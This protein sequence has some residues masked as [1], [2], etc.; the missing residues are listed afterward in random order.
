M[1]KNLLV[2]TLV[3]V[4]L[5]L[6]LVSQIQ[7]AEKRIKVFIPAGQFNMEGH[8]Q[9]RSLDWLGKHPKYGHLLR[10]LKKTDGSWAIRDDVTIS[11]QAEHRKK[12]HS[13]LTVGWGCEEHEIG[14]KLKS[15]WKKGQAVLPSPPT[16]GSNARIG[17]TYKHYDPVHTQL[18]GWTVAVDPQLMAAEHEETRREAFKALANHLQRVKY[19]V[20]EDRLTQLQELRFWI[21]LENPKLGNMQYHP[22]RGWLIANGHYP[23]LV[24]HIHI[25]HAKEL[26]DPHMWTKHPY[27]V[28]HELVHSFHDQVLSFD[29]PDILGAFEQAKKDGIYEQVLLYTGQRVRHYGLTDHKEYF[30]EATEAYFGVNDFYLFVRAELMEHYPAVFSLME[31]IWGRIEGTV[32]NKYIDLAPTPPM[33]WN[34]WNAFEVDID[35]SK[36]RAIADAMVSSGMRD[37]G[38]T[39]LVLDDGWMAP[40]R[41]ENGH[42][43]ADPKKFPS[44]MKAIGD[45]IH[46]KGLKYGIYQ[47]RGVMT[48]QQLPGSFE[49]EKIDMHTFASWGVDYI[50]MDSCFAENNGRTSPEDYALYRKYIEETGRPIVLSI[51]DFGNAA[52]VWGGKESSQLWRTS[53]DI[54]PWM[55]SVYACADTSGGDSSIHPAF[56][57]LWQ[58]AGP[59]HWNDPDM[60]QVGNLGH[61]DENHKGVADRAHFSLWCILAA[62]LMA[63]NDLTAMTENVRK[64]LTAPELIAVNQDKRGIQGYKVYD[65][66]DCEVYNKPLSDGTT[67]VLLLNKGEKKANIKVSWEKIGLS[68]TQPV[69]DLWARKNL[70]EFEDCFTT[71]NIGHHE[72]RMIKVGRPGPPLPTPVPMALDKYTVTRKGETYLSDLYYSWKAENAPVYDAAVNG[73]LIKVGSKTFK[74]GFGCKGKSAFMFKVNGLANHFRAVVAIDESYQGEGTGRF[75]IFSEDFFSNKV[76]WDS[77]EMTKDSPAKEVDI[78]LEDVH[79]LMLVFDGDDVLGNWAEALVISEN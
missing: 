56:N 60:L 45:Y 51:S 1:N 69:R 39:Y 18:E 14:P 31:K 43:M 71:R 42:L 24:K 22:D 27:V 41:D 40:E 19:V 35:E 79:C 32:Q 68:G 48:C 44:G 16:I 30:A 49:H 15:I 67:A 3:F 2:K 12:K 37:A 62:P 52:W 9:L 38:Y 58:F 77:G 55:D 75:R 59:G 13:P 63:G 7:A 64:I 5:V 65:E 47:D 20:P 8:G 36:I 74:K 54:Y 50:K 61:L 29:H 28:L 73:G 11:Y 33:G 4:V 6:G 34:S 25:P 46:S 57:G 26:Y 17:E 72:H 78:E 70:G 23:Q 21:E 66:R 76:L 53:Y 10:K